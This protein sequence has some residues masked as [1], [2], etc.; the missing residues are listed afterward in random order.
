M[1][2]PNSTTKLLYP[3]ALYDLNSISCASFLYFKKGNIAVTLHPTVSMF[4]SGCDPSDFRLYVQ[5]KNPSWQSG[6]FLLY[7]LWLESSKHI[8]Q[9]GK[10]L[11][12]LHKQKI[13]Q[14][15]WLAYAKT[16]EILDK[17][18]EFI[19]N[20][21]MSYE[22]LL[23]LIN[24]EQAAQEL[25][26][27]LHF[28]KILELYGTPSQSSKTEFIKREIDYKLL[29]NYCDNFFKKTT[30][31]QALVR[32]YFFRL[33][34]VGGFN[35]FMLSNE[36]LIP[37]LNK[38][39]KKDKTIEVTQEIN[40]EET[41]DVVSWEIFR[42]IVSP[43]LDEKEPK[44]RVEIT[45]GFLQFKNTEIQRLK[46]KCWLLA[47]NFKSGYDL[48]LLKSRISKHVA[49]HVEKDV[50]ELLALD[51]NAFGEIRD[52]IFSDEKTWLSLLTFIT[53][54]FTGGELITAG[55][56]LAAL[57][58]AAAKAYNV[59][60]DINK[61]VKKSDYALLYRIKKS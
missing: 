59:K 10:F 42:Q 2:L 22:E 20:L 46:T 14:S 35:N 12:P 55:A 33:I 51:K 7:N 11:E 4:L 5:N 56:G 37:L 6:Y 40:D 60:S 13:Y 49:I 61:T 3:D 44:N 30:I 25:M 45:S 24:I 28:E 27:H 17:A 21:G 31:Q 26:A 43:Y 19:S 34:T 47:E 54:I 15:I 50:Q 48:T 32:A 41:L 23:K 16:E 39:P 1:D 52:K 53:S 57:S 9:T 58:N 8:Q 36:K 18:E 38:L 29:Y